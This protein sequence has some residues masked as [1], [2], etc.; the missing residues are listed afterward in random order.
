MG[1]TGCQHGF[2]TRVSGGVNHLL[3][4]ARIAE[5]AQVYDFRAQRPGV[6][7]YHSTVC[8]GP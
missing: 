6:S 3:R 5:S 7:W 8:A 2:S 1:V 4:P